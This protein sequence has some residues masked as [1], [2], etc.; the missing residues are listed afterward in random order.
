M[1]SKSHFGQELFKFFRDLRENNNRE[2]FHANKKRYISDVRDPC[3]NF[4]SDF[5][6]HLI[7]I[8]EN[9]VADPR[10]VGGSL[11]RINRD[12]RF[13]K[14]K[15]P[16]KTQA[17]IHFRHSFGRKVH[18]PGFYLHLK[19]D[20]VFAATGVWR[21]ESKSLVKIRE[22]I[23][24]QPKA[25]TQAVNAKE[26]REV[27]SLTGD[28]LKR[29]PKGFDPNHPLIEDIKRK[30][31]LTIARFGEKDATSPGF[32]EKVFRAFKAPALFMEFL[33]KALDLPW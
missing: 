21:P 8:S 10:P 25:W 15:S 20:E 1:T 29:P 9:F 33:T 3:L 26:H 17:G 11:F 7:K 19:P 13:S 14:D 32:V 30:D 2:W 6:A 28:K 5:G 24:A 27:C 31:F 16:Y 12:T 23:V 22:A 18:A 4:I